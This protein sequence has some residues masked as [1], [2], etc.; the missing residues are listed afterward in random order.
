[1]KASSTPTLISTMTLLTLADSD[2]PSTSRTVTIRMPPAPIRFS[3]WPVEKISAP[4]ASGIAWMKEV[5][6][7]GGRTTPYCASRLT[8]LPDQP[9][10]TVAAATPYSSTSS[11]PMV[12]AKTS[13]RVV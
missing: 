3:P 10:A 6:I 1:M 7:P 8:T 4:L 12:Q 9:A 5:V 11:Q 13:P 2:T